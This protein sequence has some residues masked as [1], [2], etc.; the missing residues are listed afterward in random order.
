MSRKI[1]EAVEIMGRNTSAD[2]NVWILDNIQRVI[3]VICGDTSGAS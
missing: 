1:L 3:N 2:V